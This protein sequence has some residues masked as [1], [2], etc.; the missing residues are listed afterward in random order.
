MSKLIKL[1]TA[2]VTADAKP[3]FEAHIASPPS[4][5][6]VAP[7][8]K[9]PAIL[10]THQSKIP[11][12]LIPESGRKVIGHLPPASVTPIASIKDAFDSEEKRR[13]DVR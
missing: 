3:S 7:T 4:K 11:K 13:G 1:W 6:P 12:W 8:F 2:R 10:K 9:T 5:P